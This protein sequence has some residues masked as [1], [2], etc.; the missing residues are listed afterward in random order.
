MNMDKKDENNTSRLKEVEKMWDE[1]CKASDI[2]VCEDVEVLLNPSEP[3]LKVDICKGVRQLSFTVEEIK[4][5][6][7]VLGEI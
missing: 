3:R 6:A 4:A 2:K 5:L 1:Y 7:K